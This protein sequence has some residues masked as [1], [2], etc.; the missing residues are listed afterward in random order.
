MTRAAA[1]ERVLGGTGQ[2]A[3]TVFDGTRAGPVDAPVTIDVRSERALRYLATSGAQL[4]LARAYVMGDIEVEGGLYTA[5]SS[6]AG[7]EFNLPMAEQIRLLRELGGVRLLWPPPKPA[8][9]A[10]LRGRRHSRARD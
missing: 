5:L 1:L 8:Q 9:E 10:R 6:L 2:V 4:G 3:V 7:K